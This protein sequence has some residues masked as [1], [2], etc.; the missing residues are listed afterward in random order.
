MRSTTTYHGIRHTSLSSQPGSTTTHHLPKQIIAPPE[1]TCNA[2]KRSPYR[3]NKRSCRNLSSVDDNDDD[4]GHLLT[5]R[6]SNMNDTFKH[7][8]DLMGTIR[9]STHENGTIAVSRPNHL[10]MANMRE[11]QRDIQELSEKEKS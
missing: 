8:T 5:S 1:Y 10:I 6:M 4:E 11:C 3:R 7:V 2:N 9:V